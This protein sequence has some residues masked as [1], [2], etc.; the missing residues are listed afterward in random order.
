MNILYIT[1]Y[2]FP[3][4]GA[5]TMTTKG[6]ADTLR[7]RGHK[8][9]ILAPRLAHKGSVSSNTIPDTDYEIAPNFKL[10]RILGPL[11]SIIFI[12]SRTIKQLKEYDVVIAQYH[13]HHLIFPFSTLL[14]KLM[15]VPIV[16]MACDVRRGGTR[17]TKKS[18]EA[19][20]VDSL[21]D[22]LVSIVNVINEYTIRFAAK[23]LVICTEEKTTLCKRIGVRTNIEV[24]HPGIDLVEF[25]R[26]PSKEMARK[27]LWI[28]SSS[29]VLLFVGRYS[30]LEYMIDKLIRA[31]AMLLRDGNDM[32]L[33]LVGDSPT[34]ELLIEA[35]K[36][37]GEFIHFVPPLYRNKLMLYIKASDIC[38]GPL[39]ATAA[40]PQKIL[41][42]MA[43]SKPIVTGKGSVS[44]DVFN[45]KNLLITDADEKAIGEI[46]CKL[47]KESI[48]RDSLSKEGREYVS[49]F[50]WSIIGANLEHILF[51]AE[52]KKSKL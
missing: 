1:Y 26:L 2:F 16:G 24:L 9:H 52:L 36:Y 13:P 28:D 41:E 15:G 10:P 19:K 21:Q 48:T 22:S 4:V 12:A 43:A 47:S 31:I 25:E 18:N 34:K 42:Y 30:G 8:V 40:I 35:G 27:E 33:F 51:N 11:L 17:V 6:Q 32:Q 5:A 23:F 50:D 7:K 38:F 3:H 37:N 46:V 29:L 20:F 14:G 49:K 39:G 45:G 44:I